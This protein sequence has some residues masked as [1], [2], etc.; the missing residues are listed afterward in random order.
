MRLQIQTL[1]VPLLLSFALSVLR[2]LFSCIVN[3]CIMTLCIYTHVRACVCDCDL[4]LWGHHM[5]V[6]ITADLPIIPRSANLIFFRRKSHNIICQENTLNNLHDNAKFVRRN[7]INSDIRFP[8][9]RFL[10]YHKIF[11]ENSTMSSIRPNAN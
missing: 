11:Q 9:L 7:L 1:L 8:E 10:E 6:T 4:Y 5:P 3:P 2:E